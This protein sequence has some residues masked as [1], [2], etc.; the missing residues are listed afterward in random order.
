METVVNKVFTMRRQ[1]PRQLLTKEKVLKFSYFN[2]SV[3]IS[4]PGSQEIL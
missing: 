1:T 2:Q 4:C 3:Y